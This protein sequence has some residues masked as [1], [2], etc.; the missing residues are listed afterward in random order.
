[1]DYSL[2]LIIETNPKWIEYQK[3]AA[4]KRRQTR[5]EKS[6]SNSSEFNEIKSSGT[7]EF[8]ELKQSSSS[9]AVIEVE[10]GKDQFDELE[11]RHLHKKAFSKSKLGEY[12]I[13]LGKLATQFEEK[14]EGNRHKYISKNGR[15]IYHIA[16][17]DYLQAYDFEKYME[18][19]AKKWLYLPP[20]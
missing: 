2:L 10:D 12:I 15:F 9:F 14:K 1:M 19:F 13:F 20:R 18:N 17:I 16:I 3:D 11:F 4:K 5:V 6:G 7:S 8:I